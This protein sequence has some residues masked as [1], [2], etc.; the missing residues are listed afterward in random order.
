[1]MSKG[2][3]V[4]CCNDM[5]GIETD[6]VQRYWPALDVY[7]GLNCKSTDMLEPDVREAS[8]CRR[9]PSLSDQEVVI[10]E[11]STRSGIVVAAQTTVRLSP[12]T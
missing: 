7:S 9:F 3:E 11:L 6:E 2:C 5:S 8:G 4:V 10:T 12:A 1:M